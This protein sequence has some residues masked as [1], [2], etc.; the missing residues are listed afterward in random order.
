MN[1]QQTDFTKYFEYPIVY[2]SMTT[3]EN[4]TVP[5]STQECVGNHTEM[6]DKQTGTETKKWTFT[7]AVKKGRLPQDLLSKGPVG[8]LNE[9]YGKELNRLGRSSCPPEA[10]NLVK[11]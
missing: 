1:I 7:D 2:D 9:L 6:T 5:G 4:G 8:Q 3:D 10:H 11:F